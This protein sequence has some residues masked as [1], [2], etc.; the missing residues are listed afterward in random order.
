VA[1]A[2][3][4][5]DFERPIEPRNVLCGHAR[6]LIGMPDVKLRCDSIDETM[7]TIGCVGGQSA[8]V[9]T[10]GACDRWG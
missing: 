1:L 9:K 2:E 7:G 8:A 6:I 4:L 5:G 3:S 10:R